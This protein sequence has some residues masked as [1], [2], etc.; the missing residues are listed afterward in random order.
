MR[1]NPDSREAVVLIN[2]AKRILFDYR[3]RTLTFAALE[4]LFSPIEVKDLALRVELLCNKS[5]GV[6][7]K[8][9]YYED[10]A[11]RPLLI[12]SE[13]VKHY[14]LTGSLSHP[15]TRME[16]DDVSEDQIIIEFLVRQ[17]IG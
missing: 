15:E 14:F 11:G 12:P 5:V 1:I 3:Q 13:Y 9:F 2:D 16:I 4:R 7:E 8:E 6:L 17:W 10:E